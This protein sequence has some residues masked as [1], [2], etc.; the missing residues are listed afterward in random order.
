LLHIDQ[1]RLEIYPAHKIRWMHDLY[2]NSIARID[3]TRDASELRIINEIVVQQFEENPFDFLVEPYA[4]QYPF[5]FPSEELLT[6]SPYQLLIYPQDREAVLAWVRGILDPK[7][8]CETILLLT[9]LNSAVRDSFQ[10]V[11]REE[12]GVQSPSET[13][14]LGSGSCRDYAAFFMEA[15]RALGLASRFVSGYVH[16]PQVIGG[17][18]HGSTHAWVEIYV[19]GAGWKGFDPTAGLLCSD[20]HVPVA[21]AR[22]PS[23]AAPVTGSFS[24]TP[25]VF[26]GMNVLVEVTPLY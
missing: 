26:L 1:S 23:G 21:V 22:H 8:A 5:T 24:G 16:S 14:R 2:G 6:L 25:D 10:Y 4:Q 12:P 17:G 13:L 3:F 15:A 11:R 9:R 20:L 19:P 18:Q 7:Q